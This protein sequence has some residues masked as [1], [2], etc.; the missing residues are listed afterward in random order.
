MSL[1]TPKR[2]EILSSH[3]L[4]STNWHFLSAATL[5]VLNKPKDIP[6]LYAYAIE[7]TPKE[8]HAQLTAQFREGI[9]KTAALIGLPRVINGLTELKQVT[10]SELRATELLRE[11]KRDYSRE[12]EELFAQVYGKITRRVHGNLKAAYPDL[13]WFVQNFEYGPLLAHTSVLGPKE[14][15][16]VIIAALIPQDVI[17]QLKGHLKGAL[18]NGATV[19]EVNE[20]RDMVI[21]LCSW[22]GV[23]LREVS[24]L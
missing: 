6:L 21:Q 11:D 4:L 14:T 1:L 16:L 9:F 15:S 17:P 3:S 12:G 18:N 22:Y 24:K 5:N 10:P 2:L 7:Q 23:T 20:L 8:Q 19:A 13:D